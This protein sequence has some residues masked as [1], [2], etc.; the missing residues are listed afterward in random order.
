MANQWK[1]KMNESINEEE[2]F[3]NEK[4]KK[5]IEWLSEWILFLI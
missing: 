3:I 1:K 4:E 5:I 2:K